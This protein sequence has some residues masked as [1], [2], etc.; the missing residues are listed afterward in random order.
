MVRLARMASD[1]PSMFEVQRLL[2]EYQVARAS[3]R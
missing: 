1:E 2:M 3:G